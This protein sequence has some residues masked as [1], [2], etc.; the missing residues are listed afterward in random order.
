[1][2]K[3]L[4][5]AVLFAAPLAAHAVPTSVTLNFTGAVQNF[6]VPASVT[7]VT[8]EARGAQGG[9]VTGNA[10]NP[11]GGLGATMVGTFAV[12]PGDVLDVVVGG[13]GNPD[14][15]SSGGGGGSGVS[16]AGAPLIVAGG[17]AGVDFQDPNYAGQHAVVTTSGVAGNGGGGA[18][19]VGGAAGGDFV[20]SGNNVSRGGNGF[21]NG[22]TGSTG[23]N[24][25]SPN[26]TTTNGTFGLGGGGGSVG[27]GFCNC[28]GGGGGYSGGGSANINQSGGGGGSFNAGTNQQNTAGNNTGN[29][30]V[31]I[32]YD[33]AAAVAA[34]PVPTLGAWALM[35]L[36]ALLGITG[37]RSFG[38]RASR[39]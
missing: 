10:P 8:I 29:G 25:S 2:K 4:L 26:T 28:G 39:G 14:P 30:V 34:T 20:F 24:G 23:Q 27:N 22:S 5:A 38:H 13:R 21:N 3:I 32:T 6:V 37:I 31:I 19:G 18:G 35:V 9:A 1:M 17:G 12:N 36:A 7:S 33:A 16:L 11:P 15:S